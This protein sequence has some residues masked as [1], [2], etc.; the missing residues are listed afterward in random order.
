MQSQEDLVGQIER[1][2][3]ADLRRACR[4]AGISPAGSR[5]HLIDRLV[6][7]S[8]GGWVGAAC[9]VHHCAAANLA[10]RQHNVSTKSAPSQHHYAAAPQP[11]GVRGA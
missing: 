7:H 11:R 6:D 5:A 4:D 9:Q 10:P 2:P 3:L 1:M 8:Q